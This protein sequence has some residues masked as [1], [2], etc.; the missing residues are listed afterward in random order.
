MALFLVFVFYPFD[1]PVGVL[2]VLLLYPFK[3]L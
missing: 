2:E 3:L 1:N